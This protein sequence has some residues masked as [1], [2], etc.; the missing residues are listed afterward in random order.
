MDA[1]DVGSV[2]GVTAVDASRVPATTP[3]SPVE[4]FSATNEQLMTLAARG[5]RQAALELE[6]RDAGS[7]AKPPLMPE[8]NQTASAVILDAPDI[9]GLEKP[10]AAQAAKLLAS[11]DQT[12]F[13]AAEEA[14]GN[15]VD[16][17]A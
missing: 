4:L 6:N 11:A 1:A 16:K 17:F 8:E 3:V 15:V 12:A 7:E 5:N 2:S 9:L 13:E 14:V 10:D